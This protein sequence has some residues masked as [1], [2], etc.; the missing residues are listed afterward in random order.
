MFTTTLRR[1]I[2]STASSIS[3]KSIYIIRTEIIYIIIVDI[4]LLLV[5]LLQKHRVKAT[6]Q[7]QQISLL[8]HGAFR[9]PQS[10]RR[11]CRYCRYC[12]YRRYRCSLSRTNLSTTA[13]HAASPVMLSVVRI[14][15]KIR[16]RA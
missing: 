15:S 16:S 5:A 12:R 14:I 11:Y 13:A 1:V 8:A 4:V 2:S 6:K 9:L 7:Q 10:S 3:F